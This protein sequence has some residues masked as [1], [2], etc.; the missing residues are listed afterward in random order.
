MLQGLIGSRK[1]QTI[2]TTDISLT[3]LLKPLVHYFLLFTLAQM[4]KCRKCYSQSMCKEGGAQ[5][6]AVIGLRSLS[7]MGP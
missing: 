5:R 1:D 4:H 7:R 6:G 2:V 3:S